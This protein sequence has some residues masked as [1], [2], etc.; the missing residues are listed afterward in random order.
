MGWLRSLFC[1]HSWHFEEFGNGMLIVG[2][3]KKCGK[4]KHNDMAP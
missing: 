3:C 2:T 4:Q 1:K